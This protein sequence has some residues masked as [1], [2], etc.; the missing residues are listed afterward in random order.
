MPFNPE[1]GVGKTESKMLRAVK[2]LP[3][4]GISAAAVYCM[5]GVS[6]KDFT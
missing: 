2:A 5:W 3:F 6:R 4:L 1:Q